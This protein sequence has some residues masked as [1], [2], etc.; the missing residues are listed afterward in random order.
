MTVRF[1]IRHYIKRRLYQKFVM[2][3]YNKKREVILAYSKKYGCT[4]FVET[5]TFLGDT[6]DYLKEHYSKIYTIELQEDLFKNAAERFK[7]IDKIQ[8]LKGDSS[9]VLKDIV[10]AITGTT[11]FWL[12]GHYS[13]S[14]VSEG[15]FIQT[16]KGVKES[17][18][19]EELEIILKAGLGKNVILIDDARCFN[20]TS[21]Y[22]SITELK[23]LLKKFNIGDSQLNIKNDMIRIVPRSTGN[24]YGG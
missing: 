12:D 21:D 24:K 18:V 16:A 14:F 11:L 20:G 3:N 23:L 8:V 5:S 4:V 10:P 13:S 2:L 17:P 6:T 7:H 9:I 22:P 19:V 1:F 15:Q